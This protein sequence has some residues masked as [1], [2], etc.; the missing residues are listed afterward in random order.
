MAGGRHAGII[1]RAS[2]DLGPCCD[3]S[4]HLRH[5]GAGGAVVHSD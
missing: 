5:N 2:N 1:L 3:V 4:G